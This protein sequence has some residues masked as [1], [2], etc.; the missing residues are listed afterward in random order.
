MPFK[1]IYDYDDYQVN[2]FGVVKSLK[3]WRG[4]NN[5]QL[6]NQLDNNGYYK[7][8][9]SKNGKIKNHL[10]HHLVWDH[11]GDGERNGRIVQV[12]HKDE[13]K[14]NNH[15]DNLQLLTPRE[16]VSKGKSKYNNSSKYTGVYK[17][18]EKWRS[19]IYNNKQIHLGL[20]DTEYEA[21]LSY[22]KALS[23]IK[24]RFD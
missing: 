4:S 8:S 24:K 21:H 12:D 11:F 18:G 6:K 1:T 7:V 23:N 20:Y 16:N 5:R 3:S 14:L 9:L 10:I 22:Q 2:E 17:H 15:I 19:K 13:D